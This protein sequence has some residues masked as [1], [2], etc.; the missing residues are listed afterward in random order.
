MDL[1]FFSSDKNNNKYKTKYKR[2][3]IFQSF[4]NIFLDYTRIELQ[5]F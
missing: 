3:N 5:H 4:N 1:Y 2:V